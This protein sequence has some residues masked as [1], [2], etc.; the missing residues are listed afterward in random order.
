MPS[1][2]IPP[3]LDYFGY[4]HLPEN[5]AEISAPFCALAVFVADSLPLDCPEVS[6]C[7]RNLM[8][9]R[10]EASEIDDSP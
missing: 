9:S 5:L 3:I 2:N 7:L 4:D 10:L 6:A 1:D 8:E